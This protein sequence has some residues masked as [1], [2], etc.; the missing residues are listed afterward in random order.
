ML[1]TP[2]RILTALATAA[3]LFAQDAPQLLPF[4]IDLA[5]GGGSLEHRTD[6]SNLAGEA[7]AGFFRF[8]FEGIG[9]DQVGGGLRLE[10]ISSDDDLFTDAGFAA[11]EARAASMFGHITYRLEQGNLVMPIRAGLQL[12]GYGTE[13]VVTGDRVD[14]SS[15]GPQ[16]ELEPELFLAWDEQLCWSVYAQLGLGFAATSIDVDTVGNDFE[17]ASFFYGFELGTRFYAGHVAFGLGLVVRGQEVAE[18][19]DVGAVFIRGIETEFTGLLFS[20]GAVF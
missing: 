11:T 15:F 19:D 12:H 3:P 16:F 17:S 5:F 7:D 4:R 8:A 14:F 2:I 10:G 6:Q 13:E 9:D 1:S 18:S 20:V